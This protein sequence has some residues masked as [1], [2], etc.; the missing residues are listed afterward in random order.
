MNIASLEY[1]ILFPYYT[2][3]ST[4]LRL[5]YDKTNSNQLTEIS[6]FPL[7]HFNFN[8]QK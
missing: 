1:I 3:S 5:S 2:M 4:E 7:S 8:L 6:N